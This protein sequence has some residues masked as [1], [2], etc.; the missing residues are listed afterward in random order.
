MGTS[1]AS[2]KDLEEIR[3][4]YREMVDK[5]TKAGRAY[6]GGLEVIAETCHGGEFCHGGTTKT[7]DQ[8]E[9]LRQRASRSE[10]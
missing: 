9:L 1:R 10:G 2:D 4:L 3:S 6:P 8:A 5:I 7:F